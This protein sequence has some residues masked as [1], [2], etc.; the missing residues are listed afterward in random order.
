MKHLN[1]AV[2]KNSNVNNILASFSFVNPLSVNP[3][4]WSNTLKQFVSF[5]QSFFAKKSRLLFLHKSSI[6]DVRLG[7]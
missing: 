2:L 4:E 5:R 1:K 3:T 6:V 7:F